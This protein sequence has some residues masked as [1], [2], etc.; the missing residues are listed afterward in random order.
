MLGAGTLLCGV[1][2]FLSVSFIPSQPQAVIHVFAGGRSLAQLPFSL[3]S[4]APKP[5]TNEFRLQAALRGQ[6][7]RQSLGEKP[8]R[9]KA[10]PEKRPKRPSRK[11]SLGGKP[12]HPAV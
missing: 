4:A 11:G 5:A 2:G 3:P 12:S 7:E 8:L 10:A 1:K 6:L 9:L